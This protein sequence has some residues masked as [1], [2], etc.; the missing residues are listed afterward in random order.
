MK[1]L[2]SGDTFTDGGRVYEVVEVLEDGNYNSRAVNEPDD[3]KPKRTRKPK[4]GEPSE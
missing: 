3:E 4:E 2:K 1:G